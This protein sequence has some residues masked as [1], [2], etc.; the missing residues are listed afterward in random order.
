MKRQR[1]RTLPSPKGFCRKMR[2]RQVTRSIKEATAKSAR[3]TEV[4]LRRRP[5]KSHLR[6]VSLLT[7]VP[8]SGA[9]NVLSFLVTLFFTRVKKRV[10]R[11]SAGGVEA[12][13]LQSEKQDQDGFQLS[14]E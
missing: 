12:L 8:S 7:C 1:P 9:D 14:G 4:T 13:A 11:S 3:T 6:R 5:H 2:G 10:T